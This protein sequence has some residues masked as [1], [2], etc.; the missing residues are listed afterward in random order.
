MFKIP[1]VGLQW[2]TRQRTCL[3]YQSIAPPAGAWLIINSPHCFST[4]N[5]DSTPLFQCKQT[6]KNNNHCCLYDVMSGSSLVCNVFPQLHCNATNPEKN[7]SFYILYNG[8]WMHNLVAYQIE[9]IICP[10]PFLT[11]PYRAWIQI[12]S[13]SN[14]L[15]FLEELLY[16]VKISW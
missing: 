10:F 2:Q 4:W 12:I 7:P 15:Y 8:I 14:V 3:Y 13:V 5:G 16:D 1:T 11:T 6:N 9:T